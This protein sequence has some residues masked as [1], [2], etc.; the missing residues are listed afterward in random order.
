MCL[1]SREH[2]T[3]MTDEQRASRQAERFDYMIVARLE[4][5]VVGNNRD[6]DICLQRWRMYIKPRFIARRIYSHLVWI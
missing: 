5:H 6:W 1:Q 3:S 4:N 2:V